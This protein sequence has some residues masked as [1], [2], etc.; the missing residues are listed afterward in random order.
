MLGMSRG[1][2]GRRGDPSAPL[3]CIPQLPGMETLQ[4]PAPSVLT[5]SHPLTYTVLRESPAS[6]QLRC[7]WGSITLGTQGAHE[8][9]TTV[10][11]T[12]LM[13]A[14]TSCVAQHRFGP[15]GQLHRGPWVL[16]ETPWHQS[17]S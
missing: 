11:P 12:T 14:A 8:Q 15:L 13:E 10:A 5:E 4:G 1:V 7:L 2:A 6:W 16:R 9:S 3:I 17:F